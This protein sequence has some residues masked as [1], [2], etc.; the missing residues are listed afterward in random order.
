[1]IRT[2]PESFAAGK[3]SI[4]NNL[5]SLRA[6]RP[7][8]CLIP[9]SHQSLNMFKS[10]LTKHGLKFFSLQKLLTELNSAEIKKH[11]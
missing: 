3:S 9:R 1:M 10:C 5:D 4:P 7:P 8:R 2:F 11:V 6:A